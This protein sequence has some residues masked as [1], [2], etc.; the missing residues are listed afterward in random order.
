MEHSLIAIEAKGMKR[1]YLFVLM[2]SCWMAG[3][4]GTDVPDGPVRVIIGDASVG[5]QKVGDTIVADHMVAQSNMFA[6]L[7]LEMKALPQ[8]PDADPDYKPALRLCLEMGTD[9]MDPGGGV[10]GMRGP[11]WMAT[12]FQ[13]PNIVQT[14]MVEIAASQDRRRIV[15][16]IH[17]NGPVFSSTNSG[18][19][20]DVFSEPGHYK[21]PLT[22]GKRGWG[23]SAETT[24][25]PRADNQT[26]GTIGTNWYATAGQPDG[27]EFA[28]TVGGSHPVP[29]L[30]IEH[31][32]ERVI[33]SWAATFEGGILEFNDD[34]ASTNWTPVT[35]GASK[36]GQNYQVSM[37]SPDHH[38]FYRLR[39]PK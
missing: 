13:T 6:M 5:G 30:N 33:V 32:E 11:M 39:F 31:S 25:Y 12:N 28:V 35:N 19:T 7:H 22:I 36:T 24:L 26:N 18:V 23:L 14:N 9:Y 1:L 34:L 10:S 2:S 20:W 4:A 17:T 21:F 29:L 3:G 15:L 38:H 16:M 27:D 37:P 8:Q